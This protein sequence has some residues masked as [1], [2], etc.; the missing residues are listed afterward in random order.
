ML[1]MPALRKASSPAVSCV[2]S[3]MCAETISSAEEANFD[4]YS[5]S[6]LKFILI[7]SGSVGR[8]MRLGME[9]VEDCTSVTSTTLRS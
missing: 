6:V 5:D 4:E 7:S 1:R 2:G 9:D 8:F 3:H